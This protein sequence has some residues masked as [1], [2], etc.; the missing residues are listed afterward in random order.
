[1]QLVHPLNL[2]AD[3]FA[4]L[5]KHDVRYSTS[6]LGEAGRTGETQLAE[7]LQAGVKVSLSIDNVTAERCDCFACMHMQQTLNRHRT[8]GKF[9]LTTKRLV[10]MATIGGAIDLGLADKTGSLTPGKRADLILVKTGSPN[11]TAGGDAYDALVQLAQPSDVDTVV[12]DGRIVRRKGEFTALD[13]GKLLQEANETLAA[14]KARAKW[15]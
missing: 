3:D 14:L 13:Y 9:K 2:A 1:V 7:L 5:A 4:M 10:Q 15:V 6:P 8:A 12:V 11:M